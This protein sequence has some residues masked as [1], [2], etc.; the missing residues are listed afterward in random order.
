MVDVESCRK[1]L[2]GSGSPVPSRSKCSINAIMQPHTLLQGIFLFTLNCWEQCLK[3][4]LILFVSE[5]AKPNGQ[6]VPTSAVR[7]ERVHETLLHGPLLS[8]EVDAAKSAS[9][10]SNFTSTPIGATPFPT[11]IPFAPIPLARLQLLSGQFVS[12]FVHSWDW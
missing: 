9:G 11:L 6:S 5:P 1:G 8:R 10:R 7:G 2:K 12:L 4:L 3:A